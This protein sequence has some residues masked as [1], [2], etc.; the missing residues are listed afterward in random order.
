[1]NSSGGT[2]ILPLN[3]S[4]TTASTIRFDLGFKVLNWGKLKKINF[5]TKTNR[6]MQITRW[7]RAPT[8]HQACKLHRW[9]QCIPKILRLMNGP[10]YET[11]KRAESWG[12]INSS[13]NE[14]LL[15]QSQINVQPTVKIYFH[16]QPTCPPK[17]KGK[18]S[19]NQELWLTLKNFPIYLHAT[20]LIQ[21]GQARGHLR[22]TWRVNSS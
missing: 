14:A 21:T 16:F 2:N 12:L 20:S 3:K 13:S 17:S 1:M 11:M 10:T 15:C 19:I 9:E 7:R 5:F 8:R 22:R 18:L 4:T 6:F